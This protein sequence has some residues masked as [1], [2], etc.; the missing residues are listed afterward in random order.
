MPTYRAL[1][2]VA[3]TCQAPDGSTTYVMTRAEKT[4]AINAASRMAADFRHMT[5]G[6]AELVVSLRVFDDL[7]TITQYDDFGSSGQYYARPGGTAVKLNEYTYYDFF[8]VFSPHISPAVEP[9]AY[10]GISTQDGAWNIAGIRDQRAIVIHEL[11]HWFTVWANTKGH[12][13][14]TDCGGDPAIHCNLTYGYRS[15]LDINW[16][17]EFY[18]ATLPD[19][20]GLG[21][22]LWGYTTPTQDAVKTVRP[23]DLTDPT[24]WGYVP[25]LTLPER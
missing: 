9:P 18:R 16:L 10:R 23:V 7:L 19:G 5:E 13:N 6:A 17:R 20:S 12:P 2:L 11:G 15:D 22:T 3:T 8:Y 24:P 1:A 25:A 21:P 14:I 4:S